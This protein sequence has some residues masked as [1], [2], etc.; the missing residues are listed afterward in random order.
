MEENK[1][2]KT[3]KETAVMHNFSDTQSSPAL[4]TPARLVALLI[5]ALLG[6]GTGYFLSRNGGAVGPVNVSDVISTN[7]V[8]SGK[9]YGSDDLETY[10]DTTEGVLKDGGIDGEGQYHLERPGGESQNVYM[11]SS[12]VDL[13]LFLNRKIKVWGA[14]QTAQKAGWLMDVGRVQ[15]L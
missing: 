11:T 10:K 8:V 4:F 5:V 15:V 9:T 7:G 3:E 2:E 12:T 1:V 6:V 13:S 14:T